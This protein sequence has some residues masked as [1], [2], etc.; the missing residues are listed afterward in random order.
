MLQT[1]ACS[2]RKH[3]P[4][5]RG[6]NGQEAKGERR[7]RPL[8]ARIN[9]IKVPLPF[10]VGSC[11]AERASHAKS[12]ALSYTPDHSL[13]FLNSRC[14]DITEATISSQEI[15]IQGLTET[16]PVL[17]WTDRLRRLVSGRWA[18]WLAGELPRGDLAEAAR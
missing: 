11:N 7:C 2:S 14:D 17:S 6:R 1:N 15:R 3:T 13:K 12:N 16:P 4:M 5:H 10:G 18:L 9:S 8:C